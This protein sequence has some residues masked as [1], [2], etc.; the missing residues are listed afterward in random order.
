MSSHLEEFLLEKTRFHQ[1]PPLIHEDESW[2]WVQD[3]PY[4]EDFQNLLGLVG[5]QLYFFLMYLQ[6]RHADYLF[7]VFLALFVLMAE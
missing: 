5:L 3:N 7:K 1:D 4:R 6:I 2:G